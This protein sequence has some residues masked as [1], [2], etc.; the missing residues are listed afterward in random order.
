MGFLNH[1]GMVPAL[2]DQI[3]ASY[4]DDVTEVFVYSLKDS[5]NVSQVVGIITVTYTDD[6]KIDILKVRRTN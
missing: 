5:E 6:T 4:P 3:D 2:Y 1:F